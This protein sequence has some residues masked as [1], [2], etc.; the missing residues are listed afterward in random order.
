MAGVDES[1]KLGHGLREMGLTGVAA[2]QYD[3]PDVAFGFEVGMCGGYVTERV[4][5]L[6]D[7]LDVAGFQERNDE[8][9]HLCHDLCLLFR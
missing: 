1:V 9:L 4:Y 8:A 2:V 3:L 7:C 5:P 6:G